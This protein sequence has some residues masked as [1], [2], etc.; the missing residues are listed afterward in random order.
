MIHF[1][2]HFAPSRLNYCP[3]LLNSWTHKNVSNC[4]SFG[5]FRTFLAHSTKKFFFGAPKFWRYLVKTDPLFPQFCPYLPSLL[6]YKTL[7]WL[8][9]NSF[10]WCI[11]WENKKKMTWSCCSEKSWHDLWA[12]R[13]VQ[14]TCIH[15][16]QVYEG[17]EGPQTVREL[18]WTHFKVHHMMQL[19]SQRLAQALRDLRKFSGTCKSFRGPSGTSL[20]FTWPRPVIHFSLEKGPG[21]SL[22]RLSAWPANA[23]Q[24][25]VQSKKSWNFCEG[26]SVWP[27][28]AER[29]TVQEHSKSALKYWLLGKNWSTFPAIDWIFNRPT[30]SDFRS[31]FPCPGGQICWTVL[32][33][34][35][36]GLK[37]LRIGMLLGHKYQLQFELYW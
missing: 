36:S 15:C 31:R 19:W 23:Q 7:L 9:S 26:F 24:F 37:F 16:C 4:T 10:D 18:N 12:L 11:F 14:V 8:Q 2:S 27:A 20:C 17:C 1:G 32:R 6:R 25:T 13:L 22:G 34:A 28:N 30:L 33:L 3:Q 29:F 21:N 35:I 5:T